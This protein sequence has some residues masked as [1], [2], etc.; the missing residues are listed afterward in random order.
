MQEAK[1]PRWISGI[2]PSKELL[3]A[4]GTQI[5]EIEC[6]EQP[7]RLREL[8]QIYRSDPEVREQLAKFRELAVKTGPVLFVGMGASYC[9]SISGSVLLQSNGRFSFSVDA[10]EW[11]HYANNIWGDP[12]LSILLTTSGESAELVE[13]FKQ[14][15]GSPLGLICN[16]PVSTCWNLARTKLPILAGPEYG[17][18]TKTYTNATAAAIILTSEI[19]GLRWEDEAEHAAEAFAAG[20]DPIFEMR[21][22]LEEF[23]RDSANIEIVGRGAAYGGA[24]MSALCIR[25]M[26]G[27]RA[28]AHTGAG[29]KH[30]PILDV[31]ASHVAIIF[32]LGR[33]AELGFKLARECNRRGG[34][35][36]LVSSEEFD[37]T[38]KL[39]SVKI[40]AVAEPWEGITSFLV[41]QALTLGMVERT[42]CRLPPRFQY[43]VM[44]Q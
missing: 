1:A 23:C 11:L 20:V 15:H 3:A 22:R 10:G 40:S 21:G 16:N 30:G 18:A 13:L 8:I 2:E 5:L 38:D 12:A 17:N 26:S 37:S 19:T 36:V 35:V 32:A 41:P 9:S 6:R 7:A 34:K 4:T 43:G 44:E 42:G 24:I 29:F 14:D 31:D 33:T 39:F 28:A 27:H 25:E